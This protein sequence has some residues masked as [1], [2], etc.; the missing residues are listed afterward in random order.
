[1]TSATLYIDARTVRLDEYPPGSASTL[2]A[3]EM[4][5]AVA[6]EDPVLRSR[7]ENTRRWVRHLLGC[8]LDQDPARFEFATARGGKPHL[9]GERRCEF[10]ISHSENWLAIAMAKFPIGID[11][12]A[13]RPRVEAMVLAERFFSPADSL[14]VQSATK[15]AQTDVFLRQWVAKEAALKVLGM[16]IS[17]HLHRAECRYEN[18]AIRTIECGPETYSVYGFSLP[19]GSP[20]AVAWEEDIV[21]AVR[22]DSFS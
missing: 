8:Y 13:R 7:Y 2:S 3:T 11:I 18:E 12:E 22:W 6:I 10:S 21:A 19:D 1:M 9:A 5:K 20:G 16:G 14:V 17:Q 15:V 4:K